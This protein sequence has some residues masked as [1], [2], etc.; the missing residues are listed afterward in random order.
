MTKMT[1]MT[2]K[3]TSKKRASQSQRASAPPYVPVTVADNLE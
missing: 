1:K 3:A 2:K